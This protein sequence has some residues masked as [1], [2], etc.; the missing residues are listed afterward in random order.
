[1]GTTLITNGYVVS[2]DGDRNVFTNGFVRIED[3]SITAIGEMSEL[4]FDREMEVLKEAK[5]IAD[6]MLSGAGLYDRANV[7]WNKTS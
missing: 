6:R 4:A 3:D 1:M 7:P 5:I 2:V